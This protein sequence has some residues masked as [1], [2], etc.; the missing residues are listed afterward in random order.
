MPPDLI[1]TKCPVRDWHQ[2]YERETALENSNGQSNFNACWPIAAKSG[3]ANHQGHRKVI[4]FLNAQIQQLMRISRSQQVKAGRGEDD[5][6]LTTANAAFTTTGMPHVFRGGETPCGRLTGKPFKYDRLRTWGSE[7]FMHKHKEQRGAA[8]RFHPHAK[9]GILVGHDRHSLCKYVWLMQGSLLVR[10]SQLMFESEV[11]VLDVVGKPKAVE[12]NDDE[13]KL[14]EEE[15]AERIDG[16]N[17]PGGQ[18]PQDPALSKRSSLDSG[19]HKFSRLTHRRRAGNT[20]HYYRI[21]DDSS[22]D[23]GKIDSCALFGNQDE[24]A[25]C[26]LE[27]GIATRP[28]EPSTMEKTLVGPD[29]DR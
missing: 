27:G 7:C 24:R 5:R 11:N 14:W 6:F 13:D 23:R 29:A 26:M 8:A 4:E 15:G 12:L 3:H 18:P 19:L 17:G 21:S 2:K 1:S 28:R 22:A 10:S 25:C 9:R 16:G 20:Q